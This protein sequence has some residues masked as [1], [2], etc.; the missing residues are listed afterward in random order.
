MLPKYAELATR[1]LA[2]IVALA[3]YATLVLLDENESDYSLLYLT[4]YCLGTVALQ[5]FEF[6]PGLT[7]ARS[8]DV[9]EQY[10]EV[11]RVLEKLDLGVL[12]NFP[13]E[14]LVAT[15]KA[16]EL[17]GLKENDK[18]ELRTVYGQLVARL[19]R[20]P[21]MPAKAQKWIKVPIGQKKAPPT[22]SPRLFDNEPAF[23]E[24]QGFHPLE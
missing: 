5:S 24:C 8:T 23:I 13:G 21:S 18:K 9:R 22:T 17:L 1:R 12:L 19:E 11:V 2:S 16:L 7:S 3:I 4:T 15:R 14:S 10:Q 6:G 20:R